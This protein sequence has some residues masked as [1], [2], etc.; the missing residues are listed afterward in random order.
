M[1]N[2]N[3]SLMQ[4]SRLLAAIAIA[5]A[6]A[7]VA[8][9]NSGHRGGGHDGGMCCGSKACP[10]GNGGFTIAIE[11]RD[12]CNTNERCIGTG[13]CTPEPWAEAK[14]KPKP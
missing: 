2:S 12:A 11:C 14:C 9:A 8:F 7:T 4:V 1:K 3:T 6:G 13:G 5:A 10:D